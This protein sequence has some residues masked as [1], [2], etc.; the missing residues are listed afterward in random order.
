MAGGQFELR[1]AEVSDAP[2]MTAISAA[3]VA[4]YRTFAPDDWEPWQPTPQE[5]RER[6]WEDGAWAVVAEAD[7]RVVGVGG[8]VRGRQGRDGP[9]IPGLAHVAAVFVDAPWWGSGVATALLAQLIEHMR[10][11]GFREARL[12]TPVGQARAR[13]FYVR[14]GWREVAGPLPGGEFGLDLME[15]RRSL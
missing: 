3:G 2:A 4:G 1:P 5:T 15:L 6:F 9:I 12:Y 8:Y 7:G 13:A 11:A 14:E 10:A